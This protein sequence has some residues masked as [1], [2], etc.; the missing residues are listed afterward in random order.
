MA[1]RTDVEE[2]VVLEEERRP[3][4]TLRLVNLW[5]GSA[6][7]A[8]KVVQK[9]LSPELLS[10]KDHAVWHEDPRHAQWRLEPKIGGSLFECSGKTSVLEVAPG[11]CQI[12]VEGDLRVYPERLPGVPRLLAGRLRSSI[13]SF[14]VDMLVPNMQTLARGVQAYFDDLKAGTS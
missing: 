4:G 8:T 1:L 9:F 2:I 12:K 13:E 6:N 5:R 3:D 10:W 11:R 7:K 14:V